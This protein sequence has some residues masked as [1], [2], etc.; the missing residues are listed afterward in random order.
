MKT[1][2]ILL[3]GVG[4]QGVILA[5]KILSEAALL[6][7]LDIK[8]SE[9]HGMSQRGGSV[10][11]HVRIGD[12]VHSPLV[13]EGQCDLLAGFEPLEAL[14][15]AHQ[16]KPE[17]F[18][19]YSTDRINPSTVSAGLAE[20]PADLEA[21][22]GAFPC[23]KTAVPAGELAERAGN[24]RAANVVLVG[25]LADRLG[26]PD[27]VWQRALEASVPAKVLRLN[28]EAFRLGREAGG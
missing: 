22:L 13:P 23:T 24:R 10:V 15:F 4:G 20:Y 2:N 8:Q 27:E 21:R 3:S 12:V 14:R 19:V 5:S 6:Q 28:Q 18:L 7:G 26:F 16:V 25:A 9:V 17:G 1:I 11:S